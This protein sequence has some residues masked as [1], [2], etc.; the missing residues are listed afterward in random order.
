MFDVLFYIIGW[1]KLGDMFEGMNYGYDVVMVIFVW[2]V[3]FVKIFRENVCY[4]EILRYYYVNIMFIGVYV[5]I[6]LKF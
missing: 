6:S 2:Y 5:F 1:Y 3:C 4:E